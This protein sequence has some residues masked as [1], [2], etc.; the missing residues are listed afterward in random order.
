MMRRFLM[1]GLAAALVALSFGVGG[2]GGS[3]ISEGMQQGD[4]TK[5]PPLPEGLKVNMDPHQRTPPKVAGDGA[6]PHAP[7]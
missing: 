5:P 6:V 2:C 3:G 4:T 1:N 7:R